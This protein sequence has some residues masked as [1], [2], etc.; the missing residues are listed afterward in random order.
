MARKKSEKT[1]EIQGIDLRKIKSIELTLDIKVP[2]EDFD[3]LL[4]S[5]SNIKKENNKGD[6]K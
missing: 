4:M 2:K 1:E 6:K 5:M 3:K